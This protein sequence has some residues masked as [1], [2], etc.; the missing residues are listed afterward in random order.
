ML[1]LSPKG[2]SAVHEH[3]GDELILVLQG[4]VEIRFH[5]NGVR[6]RLTKGE[7][8]HF[9]AEQIHS[10][11]NV[12]ASVAQLFII[13][14]YEIQSSDTRERVRQDLEATLTTPRR[15]SVTHLEASWIPQSISSRFAGHPGF[16]M[17][18]LGL[19]RF[20]GR[21]RR[22]SIPRTYLDQVARASGKSGET[23][24]RFEDWLEQIEAAIAEIPRE[25]HTER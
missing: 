17:D 7:I 10:A 12:S 22:A 20:L 2:E 14:F 25:G 5:H 18:K 21:V 19:A 9:Y 8:I 16:V 4:E 6:T 24:K 1:V 13:R 3:P 11:V 23:L 15:A